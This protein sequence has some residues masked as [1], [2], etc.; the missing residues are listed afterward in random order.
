VI[1]RGWDLYRAGRID[2]ATSRFEDA[3]ACDPASIGARVGLAYAALRNQREEVARQLFEDVL[4]DHPD[5]VDAYIG[6]GWL[7][8]RGG[9]AQAAFEAATAALRLDPTST[10]ARALLEQ[11]QEVSPQTPP[12][13]ERPEWVRP[14][15]VEY[16]ARTS[17]DRFEIRTPAGWRPFYMNGVNLGA[18]LPGKHPSQFP[19][20]LVYAEWIAEMAAMGANTVRLY[21]IHPPGF[22]QA[23]YQHNLVH[24]E[25]AVWLVHGV[26]TELP[27]RHNYLNPVWEG[28]FFAEMH[29]VVDVLHGRTDLAHRSGHASGTYT[30]DVSNWTLAYIIGREWEPFSVET[31]NRRHPG[32]TEWRGRYLRVRAGTPMDAWLAKACEEIIAYEMDAYSEQRPVA[33]TNWPTLDPLRHPT[34]TTVPEEM[35]I[36]TALGERV[37][38]RPREYDNDLVSVSAFLVEATEEFPAGHFASY[39]A[40]PYYPDFMVLDPEYGESTSPFGPS[41]YY[42]YLR[43]LKRLHPG[44]PV[45]IAEYGVPASVGIAHLQPQGWHHG[46]HSEAAMAKIDERLT[47]EIAAAGMAGGILFAW[48]DEWFKKN[49]IVIDFEIPPDRNR[50]WLN[51][52]DA[53]QQ[54]GIFA[55]EPGSGPQGDDTRERLAA[56]EAVP[57][58]HVGAGMS[59]RA[60]ADEGYLWLLY[61]A[62]GATS[63]SPELMV[64]FDIV[65]PSAGDFR[66]PDRVGPRLPMG[67]EF[68]L[69][70]TDDEARLLADPPYNPF[71]LQSVR[72]AIDSPTRT[73]PL[74]PADTNG[75]SGWSS[76]PRG[77]FSGR[78]E[79]RYAHPY[80]PEANSDGRYDS[81]RVITNRARF[82]RA[83]DEY[84]ALGYD[85]GILPAGPL[86]DGLWERLPA[87]N[88][89]EIRIP[90][91]LLNITDPS[92][93]RVLLDTYPAHRSHR[94]PPGGYATL[95]VAD[96][97]VVVITADTEGS[98]RT[99][100]AAGAADP[101]EGVA[102]FSWP[103]WEQPRWRARRRPVFEAM[104]RTFEDLRP[105]VVLTPSVGRRV[106][107]GAGGGER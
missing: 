8:W 50:L 93:R 48:I 77:L 90:W 40:Y 84:L 46:G 68:V 52:L 23:L 3:L 103:T 7:A 97:G 104:R 4:A 102:R 47:R 49:W 10:D 85:R 59:L 60:V 12:P 1:D 87:T 44:M 27:P 76:P 38:V 100:P 61:E 14:D 98:W 78:L 54:Y 101:S 20:S 43:D 92:Q 58:T 71:R 82:T 56:W 80:V 33:Y 19:D 95:E 45:V 24:P 36:R 83:S 37:E 53:E 106:G 79:Q 28:E 15:A 91:T 63:P 69:R 9:H 11:V 94:P 86:P 66:W 32:Y 51:R 75:G 34:E 35:R 42:G 89:V 5:V 31:F 67:L 107:D 41:N 18:A 26:W 70:V 96:I 2:D 30:A 81:L 39:H 22:Y 72:N 73:P 88:A 16:P 55:M 105:T 6:L 65:D 64:G 13:V 25:Q 57:P 74:R 29:R 21:T 17:G 62:R 99:L